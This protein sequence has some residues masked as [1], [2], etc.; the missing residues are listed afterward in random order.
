MIEIKARCDICDIKVKEMD[1]PGDYPSK[2]FMVSRIHTIE[3]SAEMQKAQ[4]Q[5][6]NPMMAQ[7]MGIDGAIEHTHQCSWLICSF[8]CLAKFGLMHENDKEEAE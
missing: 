6:V 5:Q 2:W 8:T 7:M 3:E 4:I 1:H